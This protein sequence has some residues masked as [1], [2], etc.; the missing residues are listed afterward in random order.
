LP[1]EAGKR[2]PLNMRTTKALR[3]RLENAARESGRSL[4]QEVEH[5]LELSF[6]DED[7]RQALRELIPP[8][9][10]AA[11]AATA[12]IVETIRPFLD[13]DNMRRIVAAAERLLGPGSRVEVIVPTA[14][15]K[16][17]DEQ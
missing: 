8:E 9:T 12:K 2:H 17:D 15:Q 16:K 6:R 4:V 3:E 14:L 1:P 11:I 5:R 13:S 10:V 7:Q